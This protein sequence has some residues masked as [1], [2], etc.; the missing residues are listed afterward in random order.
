MS[1]LYNFDHAEYSYNWNGQSVSVLKGITLDIEHGSFTCLIG[2]SGVGKTTLL[3]VMGLIEHS[4]KGEVKFCGENIRDKSEDELEELRLKS[5][6][7][8]FQAF[9]L[10]P[11]LNVLENAAYFLPLLGMPQ[12]K[13]KTW[14]MEILDIV[15]L[16][17]HWQKKPLELSGGQRQ[18]VAIARALVKKPK[19]ILADEPTANL[20]S[21]TADK[22]IQAFKDIQKAENT[23]F[24][25]ATH[26]THLMS[27]AK[28]VLRMKDGLLD[29]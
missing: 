22:I 13:A 19:V 9:Y 15:G 25:F 6:G 4:T 18:R 11:T 7:F 20:D 17:D 23:S 26:D 8:V 28:K 27:Y 29:V 12:A 21:Q 3:N 24:I 2:P 10:I 1:L 16:A 14:T 5:I